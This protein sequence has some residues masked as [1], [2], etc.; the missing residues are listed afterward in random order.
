MTHLMPPMGALSGRRRR[1]SSRNATSALRALELEAD[2]HE[3]VRRP[4]SRVEERQLVLVLFRD[5][6]DLIV[7]GPGLV[8]LHEERGVHDHLVADRLVR[9]RGDG[10]VAQ[11]L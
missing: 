5:L 3:V 7:E 8:T 4:R 9:A 6:G 10:R 2:V 11:R 1:S